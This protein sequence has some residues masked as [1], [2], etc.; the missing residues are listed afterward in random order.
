MTFGT[1]ALIV[2][3]GLIGPLLAFGGRPLV[4]VVVGE[5]VAGVII[6]TTGFRWVD[7]NAPTTKFLSEVGF[8]MVMLMAGTH[9]PV[10]DARMRAAL[11]VGAAAAVVV[12]LAAVP[13][14]L[15]IAAAFHLGHPGTWML[16]V[17]TGSAAVVLPLLSET[18]RAAPWELNVMAQV[19]VADIATIALLP[20]VI[21]PGRAGKAALGGLAVTCT[22]VVLGCLGLVGRRTGVLT[23]WRQR[24][25]ERDWGLEL[26]FSLLA[27][28]V[29]A[30]LAVRTETSVLVAG[31]GAGLVVRRLGEPK[32]LIGQLVGVVNGLFA[33]LF[34]VVL[35][36]RLD[37]RAVAHQPSTI[38]LA[39]TLAAAAIVAHVFAAAATRQP[40]ATGLV[41]SAQ[42]GVPAAVASIGL[43]RGVLTVGRASAVMLAAVVTLFAA[44][45]GSSL[46]N[47]RRGP[48]E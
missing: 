10:H 17:A 44:T 47:P 6:G 48:L 28:F 45:I 42:L 22:A 23:R 41:A 39:A 8:A 37:L 25:V 33:P 3:A 29:L 1:L 19:T 13:A 5:L 18:G 16:L 9:V 21:E 24:S 34:F 31:F 46:L 15:V 32:R 40:A 35:G 43:N 12:A 27:V 20:L 14:G 30:W 4:P 26:R 36:A 7:A 11:R 2:G 38:A